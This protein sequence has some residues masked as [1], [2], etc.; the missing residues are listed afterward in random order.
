MELL[1]K[2]VN[3]KVNILKKR[4]K[5]VS[6][7]F[8]NDV[9]IVAVPLLMSDKEA[10]KILYKNEDRIYNRLILK[11]ET[12]ESFLDNLEYGKKIKIVGK[13]FEIKECLK[14]TR[15]VENNIIYLRKDKFMTDLLNISMI[16]LSDYI[17]VRIKQFYDTM[18]KDSRYPKIEYNYVKGYYGKCYTKEHR[19]VFN[20]T[21]A[22]LDLELID[23]VIVH[24]LAH[25]K[26]P[27]HQKEFHD[28]VCLVLP[29]HRYLERRLKKEGITK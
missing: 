16:Y 12:K 4:K 17:S 28:Y 2:G 20:V 14:R 27:N 9:L 26:Y 10:I 5:N 29:N 7:Y 15:Y 3:I 13:E 25:I 6:F 19:I 11:K 18:Y 8:D 24:E 23:Y 21:L 22:F 1:L